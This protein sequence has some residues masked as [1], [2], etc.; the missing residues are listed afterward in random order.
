MPRWPKGNPAGVT[1]ETVSKAQHRRVLT[2]GEQPHCISNASMAIRPTSKGHK[3]PPSPN[4]LDPVLS[5]HE[6]GNVLR[7]HGPG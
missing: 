7:V 1:A 4:S 5:R 3:D 6:S 2:R